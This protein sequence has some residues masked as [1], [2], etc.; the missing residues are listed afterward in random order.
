MLLRRACRVPIVLLD[1]EDEDVLHPA[2]RRLA[3]RA[4]RIFKR[5]LPVDRWR[6]ARGTV[7][8]ASD[9]ARLRRDPDA[10]A[11]VAALRPLPLGLPFG[12]TPPSST[13]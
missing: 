5:E 12:A 13:F 4:Q 1:F 9:D 8:R 11:I 2:H 3:V 6:L 10:R 7:S